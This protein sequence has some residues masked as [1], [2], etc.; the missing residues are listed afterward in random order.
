MPVNRRNKGHAYELEVI[1]FLKEL[2]WNCVS[3]RS[4]SKRTDDAGID[5]CYSDPFAIQAK[6]WER[7]P[8]YHDILKEMPEKAG[9]F[10]LL[11]HKKNRRGTIVSMELDTFK[12]IVEMLIH[13]GV[14]KPR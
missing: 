1:R 8:S 14:L 13:S 2:G 7:A 6:A 12:E 5:I 4:E 9:I 3:S 10:N 11:F